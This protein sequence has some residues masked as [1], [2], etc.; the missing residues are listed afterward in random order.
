MNEMIHPRDALKA[1]LRKDLRSFLHKTFNTVSAADSYHHN[2]HIDAI[3]HELNLIVSGEN[4][5]LVINQPPRSL[6]SICVSVALVAWW[7]GH[8]P[9]KRFA[10]VSYSNELAAT[11]QRQFRKVV[12][13]DWYKDLFPAVKFD[14]FTETE[15][16][17][18]KGGGRFVASI[19]GTFTGK[20]ADVII[21]DDPM[22]AS[23]ANSETALRRVNEVYSST[24]LS[25]FNNK[26]SGALI[27]VMQRLHEDDLSAKVLKEEGCRHLVLSA[28]AEE[29]MRIQTGPNR[30]YERKKDEVLNQAHEPLPVYERL[31]AEMGSLSFSTQYQQNPIPLEGN[32]IKREW[33]K[34]YDNAPVKGDGV[35]IIQSWDIATAIGSNNDYSVCTTWAKVNRDYYLLDVWRGRLEFPK[36]RRKVVDLAQTHIPNTILI[37]KSGPG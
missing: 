36:L 8:D 26:Q 15:C 23:D 2:W 27:L 1:L 28:I 32:L 5:K 19:D 14:K 25:R 6:K 16:E 4:R 24:L 20:G 11:F 13:S 21:I 29:D 7:L 18:T 12:E 9:S 10:V 34:F 37:E 33:F 17:T 22:K 31:K 35:Q 30:F 3:L